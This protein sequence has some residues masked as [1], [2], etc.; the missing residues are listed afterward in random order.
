[1]EGRNPRYA[2]DRA[3]DVTTA[4]LDEE[5]HNY[6]LTSSRPAGTVLT[7]ALDVVAPL[8]SSAIEGAPLTLALGELALNSGN[9]EVAQM[10]FELTTEQDAEF[11]SRAF[12]CR[13]CVAHG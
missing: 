4:Q 8:S 7:G 3:F 11:R 10:L 13:R 9:F 5:F 2:Y 12:G 1:M 6:L